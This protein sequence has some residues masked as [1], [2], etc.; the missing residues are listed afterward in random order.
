MYLI[1]MIKSYTVYVCSAECSA[2]YPF[3]AG[4]PSGPLVKFSKTS[5]VMAISS[6]SIVVLSSKASFIEMDVNVAITCHIL[7]QFPVEGAD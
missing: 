4:L 7:L 3:P 1:I 2:E 6:Y 5:F